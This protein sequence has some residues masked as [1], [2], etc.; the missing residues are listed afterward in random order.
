MNWD[1]DTGGV[2]A[3]LG[4]ALAEDCAKWSER[5][6]QAENDTEAAEGART[7]ASWGRK[8]AGEEVLAPSV[9]EEF[10]RGE[11]RIARLRIGCSSIWVDTCFAS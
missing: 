5:W 7:N 11:K 4:I 1:S 8:V 6:G 3:Q 10:S 9:C 2:K